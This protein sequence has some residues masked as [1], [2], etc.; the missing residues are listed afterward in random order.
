MRIV[1]LYG[2]E[3]DERDLSL[4]SGTAVAEV[5]LERG[6]QVTLVDPLYGAFPVKSES[7]LPRVD[8]TMDPRD[9]REIPERRRCLEVLTSPEV[10]EEMRRAD[11]VF[12]TLTGGWGGDGHIQAVLDMMEVRYTCAGPA[13]AS[14]ALDKTVTRRLLHSSGVPVAPA[15]ATTQKRSPAELRAGV[16]AL[17]RDGPVVVKPV[18]GGGSLHVKLVRTLGE[19][20]TVLASSSGDLLF[21]SYL[22]GREF[23]VGIIGDQV[24][25]I[26][27]ITPA[28]A[29]YGYEDKRLPG[30]DARECPA[31]LTEPEARTLRALA[32]AAHH[33]IGLDQHTCSRVDFRCDRF[34]VPHCLEVNAHPGLT[35]VSMFPH[36]A[37]AAGLTFPDLITKI[38]ELTH[39]APTRP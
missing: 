26:I 13:A 32:L 22:P 1:I 19:L 37:R 12:V 29:L 4:A 35:P 21:E 5:L 15:V 25:P 30:L 28:D 14:H 9:I 17:L 27:E 7:D 6:D 39:P 10:V 11:L 2:G 34:G 31:R 18:R 36:A 8:L 20:D 16:A 23:T 38:I 3:S 24:L 33:A